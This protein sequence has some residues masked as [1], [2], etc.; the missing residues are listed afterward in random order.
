MKKTMNEAI[1]WVLET[2]IP[3]LAAMAVL[4]G[5]VYIIGN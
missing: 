2:L 3:A 5:I 1:I 4:L